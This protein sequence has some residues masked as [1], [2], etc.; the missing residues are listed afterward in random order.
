MN[1]NSYFVSIE[2]FTTELETLNITKF[3]RRMI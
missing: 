2:E 1:A 3:S